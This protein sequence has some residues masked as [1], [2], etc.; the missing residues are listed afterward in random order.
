MQVHKVNTYKYFVEISPNYSKFLNIE[1][2]R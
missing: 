1:T 2:P